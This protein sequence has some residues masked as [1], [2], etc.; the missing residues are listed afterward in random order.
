MATIKSNSTPMSSDPRERRAIDDNGPIFDT[1]TNVPIEFSV[2]T[3]R[4]QAAVNTRLRQA[5][6]RTGYLMLDAEVRRPWG[7][8]LLAVNDRNHE[9]HSSEEREL[10]RQACEELIAAAERA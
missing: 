2:K 6:T 7:E 5:W 1:A 3:R 10:V 8:L 9:R 4:N